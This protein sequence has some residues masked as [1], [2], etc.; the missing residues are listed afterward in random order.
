M[1]GGFTAMD[2]GSAE[3]TIALPK[4]IDGWTRPD[5]PRRITAD[6]IFDYMDGAGELYIGYR[7]RYLD[8]IE[9]TSSDEDQ[10]LVELYWMESS[11]D[12]FGLL[13]GDWGGDG[14]DLS[15]PYEAAGGPSWLSPKRALYGNGLLRIW[16]GDLYVRIMAY[17]DTEKSK[18]AV[19]ALG[20]SIVAGRQD[21]PPPKLLSALPVRLKAGAKLRGNRVCY[22]R[23]HLVLNAI[24]FLSA[25]NILEF[26]H[27][28]EAVTASYESDK[29]GPGRRGPQLIL[30]RYPNSEAAQKALSHFEKGYL[31]EKSLPADRVAG[32]PTVWQI[33]EGWIGYEIAGK[34]LAV[35]FECMTR[36]QAGSFV[37]EG[38]QRFKDLEA[39]HD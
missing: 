29:A 35:V 39:S 13:S 36:E 4:T 33:E 27:S 2:G 30:A 3:T 1:F 23:S 26:A 9:Y 20:R 7:F 15:P 31:P 11:N 6:T 8:V 32:G 19:L 34:D 14:I 17:N 38:I 24:Y 18:H 22:F 25:A 37:T 28:V 16:S 5:Q 12:A 10:I 21:Q